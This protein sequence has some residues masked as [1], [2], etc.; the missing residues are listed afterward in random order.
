M[1]TRP[2]RSRSGFSS[3]VIEAEGAPRVFWAASPPRT[4]FRPRVGM[5]GTAV[6]SIE[7]LPNTG[8]LVVVE[9][10][11]PTRQLLWLWPMMLA[12][13][14][15]AWRAPRRAPVLLAALALMAALTSVLLWQRDY[16]RRAT[17]VDADAYTLAAIQVRAVRRRARA[18]G[19]G[20]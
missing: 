12:P 10:A 2:A 7:K 9:Y 17:H 8:P 13:L 1:A 5:A 20:G 4:V 11:W 14:V 19:A 3:A 15:W 18:A 16:S 6:A